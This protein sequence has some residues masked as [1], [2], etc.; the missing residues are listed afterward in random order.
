[1]TGSS[2]KVINMNILSELYK[3]DFHVKFSPIVKP[4]IPSAIEGAYPDSEHLFPAHCPYT[5]EEI[6]DKNFYPEK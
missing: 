1:M 5:I 4:Y 2:N 3:T 6:L